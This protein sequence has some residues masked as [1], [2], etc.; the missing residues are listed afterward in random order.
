MKP[1]KI[2]VN[3]TKLKK[4]WFTRKDKDGKVN[5]YVQ[6]VAWPN[7]NGPDTYGNTHA[8]KQ[9]VPRDLQ[10]SVDPKTVP[11]CGNLKLPDEGG[12][13]QPAQQRS[14][15]AARPTTRIETDDDSS[16]PF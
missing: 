10:Q 5:V 1:I 4:E 12:F 11:F 13:Q 9:D 2:S 6:L 3:V 8:V 7:R 16:V 15:P 14:A